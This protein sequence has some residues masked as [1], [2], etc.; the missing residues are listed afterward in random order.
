MC[1]AVLFYGKTSKT[2]STEIKLSQKLQK[3][4]LEK[5]RFI[6][7]KFNLLYEDL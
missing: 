2:S 6:C 7:L 5:L 3:S 1:I 4:L